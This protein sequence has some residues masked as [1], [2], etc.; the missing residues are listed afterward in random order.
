[1]RTDPT[2]YR[3]QVLS[4]GFPAGDQ[5]HSI[6]FRLL[7]ERRVDDLVRQAKLERSD[8]VM[9]VA[10]ARRQES[11]RRMGTTQYVNRQGA[12]VWV[13]PILDWSHAEKNDHMTQ[14]ALP[15]NPVVDNLHMSGECL[16]GSYAN[17]PE[18][19]ELA[20]IEFFYPQVAWGIR[21]LEREV[22]S[23]GKWPNWGQFRPSD[24]EQQGEEQ[25]WLPL[26]QDCPTRWS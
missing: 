18:S 14:H 22:F 5:R 7:K 21:M 3:E 19:Q 23:A 10:G 4:Q 8:R 11:Q 2:V 26:C 15:R 9:L 20:Q 6:M 13:N 24:F 25:P 17:M 12:K 1:L 16:C